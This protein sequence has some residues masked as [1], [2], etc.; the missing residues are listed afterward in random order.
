MLKQFSS[1]MELFEAFP[2]DQSA[3]DHFTAIR[4]KNGAF[5]PHCGSTR[6]MHFKDKRTHKCGDCRKRFSITVGT[7]FGDT[8]LSLRKWFAAIWLI[9]NHPKG[10]ASTQL[11]KELR[12][13]QK[14]AWFVLHRLR[15][16]SRTRS[17]ARPLAGEVEVDESMFGGKE[18]NKPMSKRTPAKRSHRH[19]DRQE[20]PKTWVIGL[21]ERGGEVRASVIPD[22][23]GDTLQAHVRANVAAGSILFTDEN[24]GY[25]RLSGE[26][27]HEVVTHNHG[28]YVR[29]RAHVNGAEGMWSL[30]KRQY[31]GTHHWI[32]PKHLDAYLDEM[33]YRWNRRDLELGE[34]VNDLLAQTEGRR[35][36]YKALIA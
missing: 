15:Y 5:C 9:T 22:Q 24:H 10:I 26:Y 17:F 2:D 28:E 29:G 8:K 16:A 13:T 11:A 1:L 19:P 25:K 14:S 12:I 36:T 35:L 18:K 21:V 20:V 6:V 7:V 3:I 32:S 31:H 4:W 23:R 34:R 27:V 30:F 33:C